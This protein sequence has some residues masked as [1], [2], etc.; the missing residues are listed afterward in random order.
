MLGGREF[1][2]ADGSSAP[3]VA[4]I[5]ESLARERFGATNPIGKRIRLGGRPAPL[6]IVGIAHDVMS[7][8]PRKSAGPAVYLSFFQQKSPQLNG[9]AT[10]GLLTERASVSEDAIR[11]TIRNHAPIAAVN[12][13]SFK[14]IVDATL[15]NERLLA[16]LATFF[17][18]LALSLAAV[19][20]Y[21]LLA[22]SVSARTTEIG[23]RGALGASRGSV[24]WLVMSDALRLVAAGVL[25]GVPVVWASM[26]FISGM[27]FGLSPMDPA[28]I[29]LSIGLIVF[30]AV[31]AAY[32]PARRAVRINP[33]TALKYD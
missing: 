30:A 19:G 15:L 11:A 29:A 8:G 10:I 31:I 13:R 22:F 24:L 9:G 28:V 5:N 16:V 7:E 21:G 20:L 3:P 2:R 4:I 25:L 1:S 6:T 18:V 12:V 27:L 26:R 14:A 17:G 23:V 33:I 32:L